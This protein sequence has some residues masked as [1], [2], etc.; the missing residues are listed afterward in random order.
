MEKRT[1]IK[2]IAEKLG[3]APSTVSRA[4]QPDSR[5]S[6]S[7]RALILK[8]AKEM[9]YVPNQAASRLNQREMHIGFLIQNIYPAGRDQLLIGIEEAYQD[10]S[11]YKVSYHVEFFDETKDCAAYCAE[12]FER[13]K[14]DDGIIVSG[15]NSPYLKDEMD[16]FTKKGRVV[17]LLQSGFDYPNY[18]FR[19][20]HHA[21]VASHMAAEYFSLCTR[22]LPHRRVIQFTGKR[23]LDLHL[24][25]ELAFSSA[26]K[27]YGIEVTG[28]YDMNDNE[29]I[30]SHMAKTILTEERLAETE[31]IYITSGLCLPLC[32]HLEEMG[33]GDR[34]F[35]ITT[36]SFPELRPYILRRTVNASIYQNFYQQAWSAY[37]LLAKYLINHAEPPRKDISPHP[38]LIMRS[39][40]EFYKVP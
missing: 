5:I 1:T 19:V 34:I 36:D 14:E 35:L 21:T 3:V 18:L 2:T 11:D 10:F 33:M 13:C 38:E 25:A 32:R 29:E 39:N 16:R 12:L 24:N 20:T 6:D 22:G 26:C 9:N 23:T 4:F 7:Q 27:E 37:V 31:G 15:I 17:A 28:V 30:L 8:T 40:L